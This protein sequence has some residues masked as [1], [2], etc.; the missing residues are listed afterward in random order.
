MLEYKLFGWI[1]YWVNK[2][3]GIDPEVNTKV[4][5]HEPDKE[6]EKDESHLFRGNDL[7]NTI[8]FAYQSDE[9]VKGEVPE[10]NF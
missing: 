2:E 9:G 5:K 8:C 4:E 3:I 6:S 10:S 1:S 7:I